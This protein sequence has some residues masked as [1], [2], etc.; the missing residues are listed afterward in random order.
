V[1]LDASRKKDATT[2]F[3]LSNPSTINTYDVGVN[4]AF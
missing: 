2:N 4:H 3:V 1:Y